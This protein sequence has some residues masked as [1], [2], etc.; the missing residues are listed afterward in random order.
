[1]LEGTHSNFV[2]SGL[3]GLLAVKTWYF[4]NPDMRIVPFGSSGK[5]FD[6]SP[7]TKDTNWK[8]IALEYLHNQENIMRFPINLAFFYQLIGST[9]IRLLSFS[10]YGS[11][12][13]PAVPATIL[14]SGGWVGGEHVSTYPTK[15]L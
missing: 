10:N 14:M 4:V 1:M 8:K 3:A 5:S 12:G 13:M 11:T 2:S 7:A 6:L 9:I 15:L